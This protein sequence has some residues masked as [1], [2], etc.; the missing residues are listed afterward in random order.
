MSQQRR[1][2]G[3]Q[4]GQEVAPWT[5]PKGAEKSPE[6]GA[7]AEST[8]WEASNDFARQAMT[9]REAPLSR[10]DAL[11]AVDRARAALQVF[12]RPDAE[13][14]VAVLERSNLPAD[15]VDALVDHLRSEVALAGEVSAAIERWFGADSS[16][17]RGEISDG[18]AALASSPEDSPFDAADPLVGLARQIALLAYFDEDEEEALLADYAAEERA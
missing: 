5:T 17:I 12:A 15:R 6:V 16:E 13:R 9:E 10:G 14:L 3:A 8:G 7:G 2:P 11:A 18:F 1:V 4:E